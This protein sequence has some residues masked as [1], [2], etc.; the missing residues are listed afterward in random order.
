MATK[1]KQRPS[2]EIIEIFDELLDI[3]AIDDLK[4]LMKCRFFG[5]QLPKEDVDIFSKY[6]SMTNEDHLDQDKIYHQILKLHRNCFFEYKKCQNEVISKRMSFELIWATAD[7]L[8]E[9]FEAIILGLKHSKQLYPQDN[10]RTKAQLAAK[11]AT[12]AELKRKEEAEE[13]EEEESGEGDQSHNHNQRRRRRPLKVFFFLLLH[14][15]SIFKFTLLINRK[16]PQMTMNQLMLDQRM[17]EVM[18]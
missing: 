5:T 4:H 12:A 13:D 3:D 2:K 18:N 8:A 14:F 1:A 11:A 6:D 16:K 9:W 17:E 15:N 7:T 10:S